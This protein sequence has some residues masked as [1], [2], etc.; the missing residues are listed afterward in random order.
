[1]KKS[2]TVAISMTFSDRDYLKQNFISPSSLL[3]KA[4][5]DHKNNNNISEYELGLKQDIK[6]MQK[7]FQDSIKPLG[8]M[9]N[10]NLAVEKFLKKYPS[11]SKAE[12]MARAEKTR[13][14]MLDFDL[15]EDKLL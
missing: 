2:L 15:D 4:I 9:E 14:D 10:Y 1:M 3:K 11:W 12:I 7:H 5:L 8:E 6:Y 13:R